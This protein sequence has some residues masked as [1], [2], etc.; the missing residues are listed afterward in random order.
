MQYGQG[1]SG[2]RF[3]LGP[4]RPPAASY[5]GPQPRFDLGG[6]FSSFGEQLFGVALDNNFGEQLCG[7]ALGNSFGKQE[8]L[9]ATASN[10]LSLSFSACVRRR[11]QVSRSIS[12]KNIS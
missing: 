7:A 12:K 9:C 2:I 10:S 6:S 3:S 5:T 8:Q 1:R 4:S 11:Y